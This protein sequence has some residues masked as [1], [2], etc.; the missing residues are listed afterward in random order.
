VRGLLRRAGTLPESLTSGRWLRSVVPAVVLPVCAAVCGLLLTGGGDRPSRD[1]SASAAAP[2]M[3]DDWPWWR[4]PYR[5]GEARRYQR[6]PLEWSDSANIVWK[7]EI[8]GRGHGSPIAVGERIFLA[9]ADEDA[10]QQLLLC[11]D[12]RSGERRWMTIVHDGNFVSG[13]NKKSTHA[14]A[15]PACDGERVYIT[16][17]NNG[18]I[19][20]SALSLDGEQLWQQQVDDFVIHQGYGA[21][22][23][24]FGSLVLVAADHKGGGAIA[25]LDRRTGA[26]VWKQ[27]RPA[28]A[29]YTSPIIVHANNRHQ[30][31]Y[32][33]C[34]KVASYDPATGQPLWEVA[35]STTECVTS[36]V[37]DG[38]LVYSTGGYPQNHVQAV[39]ADGSGEIA[40]E[41]NVRVYVPSLLERDGHLYLVTDDGIAACWRA[42]DGEELWKGRLGGTFSSSP[43]LVDDRIYVT[44]ESGLTSVFRATPE[45]FEQL[46]QSQL[47]NEV[48]ATPVIARDRILYRAAVVD[49]A[50]RQD[51]LYCLG[52]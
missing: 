22:P 37:S 39:V 12:R 36:T 50:H 18:A 52:E 7:A 33:G 6:P 30:L 4:G 17:L 5:N 24:V 51:W 15:T 49:G 2:D 8:P 48:F 19:Y 32:T 42:A 14:S 38:N 10:Q 13:G 25:G 3:P 43:V 28:T 1:G 11:L 31:V 34:N 27:E 29:N 41:K 46:A 16:F 47:G 26:V 45:K 35:G 9:T 23:T 20:C 21:S 44:D 40:W